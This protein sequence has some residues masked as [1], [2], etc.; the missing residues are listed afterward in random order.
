MARSVYEAN[1]VKQVLYIAIGGLITIALYILYL[2]V[3]AIVR[4]K[5]TPREAMFVCDKHG[6][7]R[8]KHIIKF[9]IG[10][11]EYVD[12]C[13]RCFHERLQNAEKVN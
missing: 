4:V 1:D 7:I 6:A 11:N 3:D 10:P 12:Y 2:W 9:Q 13:P 5:M 8:Q